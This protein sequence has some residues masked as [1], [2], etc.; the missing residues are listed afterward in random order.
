MSLKP[1]LI[2]YGA[3][4]K[5]VFYLTEKEVKRDNVVVNAFRY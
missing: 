5:L 2:I 3:N 4:E 1:D